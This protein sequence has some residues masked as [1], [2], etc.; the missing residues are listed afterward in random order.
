MKA[1]W[2]TVSKHPYPYLLQTNTLFIQSDS[3]GRPYDIASITVQHP[4]IWNAGR[5]ENDIDFTK[6]KYVVSVYATGY[7]KEFN[8]AHEALS[9]AE[10]EIRVMVQKLSN[11]VTYTPK[12]KILTYTSTPKI[13]SK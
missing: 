13:L 12:P 3:Q 1:Y 2:E 9:I 7:T 5:G 6:V 10:A 8:N 11:A 4:H